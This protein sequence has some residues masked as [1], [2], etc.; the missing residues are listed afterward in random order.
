MVHI[1]RSIIIHIC[2]NAV[3]LTSLSKACI[4]QTT[5]KTINH[6]ESQFT[7]KSNI[8]L[9]Y[10]IVIMIYQPCNYFTLDFL[11]FYIFKMSYYGELS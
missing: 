4:T 5:G 2:V 8:Y 3:P 1:T 10:Y 6:L 9:Y 11:H 7:T